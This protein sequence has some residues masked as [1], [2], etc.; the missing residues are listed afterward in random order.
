M[1]G[2]LAG[3]RILTFTAGVAGPN[4]A[5]VLAQC[6]AEVIKLESR[7]GGLDSFRYFSSDD[8]VDA[9]PRFIE[10][11]LNVLSAQVNL[12]TPRGVELVRELAAKS[13]V[14]LDNFRPDVLPRLG[15]GPEELRRA[16]PELIVV[17]MPGLGC[18]GPKY[19][20]GTWG[21]TLTAFSGMTWLWNHPGQS[22]P[23]GAQGVYPDYLAAGF[24]PALVIA[25]LLYRQR[26]GQGLTVDLAQVE[27]T[28]YLLGVS[29][30]EAAVNGREPAPAGNDWP[31]S[32]PHN[33][34][35]CR[36]DDRWCV[37]AVETDQQWRSLCEVLG[38]PEL[39]TDP[40]Y[41]T[42]LERR[43]HLAEVDELVSAWTCERD[44][45]TVLAALQGASVP[46]GVVQSGED[47]Y[48]DPQL[49]ARDFISGI[50]HPT[51][52]NM[53][54]AAVPMHLEGGGLEP[55]RSSALL[56]EQNAY[57][58]CDILGYSREQLQTWQQEGVVV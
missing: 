38:K 19:W 36:G 12:K 26:T 28:A 56:G 4:A 24:T 18:T 16:K 25:A 23:I 39:G 54:L 49:R 1:A 8:D 13:D 51:L 55:P 7:K 35:P 9:S 44:A 43:R 32:A 11:N 34:Y 6:G 14:V 21:S 45:H 20:Y 40:R 22:R 57:V 53:P 15:L 47:L 42:L 52:G 33:T 48:H 2:F 50:D 58:F 10:A 31:S 37:V 29:Y 27:A 30:L 17:K 46:C 41:A 3:V 5:R